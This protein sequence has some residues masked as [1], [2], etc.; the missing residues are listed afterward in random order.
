MGAT[1]S[2]Q[3]PILLQSTKQLLPGKDM[4]KIE[5]LSSIL[6]TPDRNATTWIKRTI[7]LKNTNYQRLLKKN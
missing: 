4:A 7:S 1:A 6:I 5:L 3:D 2:R